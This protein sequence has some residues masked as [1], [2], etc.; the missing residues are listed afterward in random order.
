MTQ[1]PWNTPGSDFPSNTQPAYVQARRISGLAV[2][3]LVFSLVCCLPGT[4]A[5]AAALGGGALVSIG[6]SEGRLSGRPLAIAGLVLGLLFSGVWIA[7]TLGASATWASVR[8]GVTPALTALENADLSKIQPL[9]VSEL[10]GAV[11]DEQLLRFS[12]EIKQKLGSPV[13]LPANLLTVTQFYISTMFGGTLPAAY[14]AQ[15]STQPPTALFL[16]VPVQFTKGQ[17][18]VLLHLPVSGRAQASSGKLTGLLRNIIIIT[19]DGTEIK[20]LP[21]D[22]ASGKLAGEP[23]TAPDSSEAPASTEEPAKKKPGF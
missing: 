3:S 7:L 6:K 1:G 2:S 11:G 5:I 8:Q 4:G 23:A 10:T 13:G 17:A 12:A 21:D 20:L 19:A 18:T 14:L 9:M 16:P 15:M 22:V